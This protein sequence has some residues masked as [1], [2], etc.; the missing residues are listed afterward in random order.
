VS[1]PELRGARV[2]L[3]PPDP[4][5]DAVPLAALLSEPAVAR[6]WNGPYDA[7]R[8]RRDVLEAEPGWIIEV[9]GELAGWIQYYEETD[10][11]YR[12]VALD[13][14]LATAHHGRGLGPE[15]LRLV[16]NHFASAGHHRFTIDPAA[17]NARAIRAYEKVG[18]RPVGRLRD[19]ERAPDGTWHDGLLMDLLVSEL[20]PAS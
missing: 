13:L 17:D 7:Q 19:Y 3:R 6:W 14:S 8:A 1:L 5:A 16:V 4:A 2:R 18:F 20:R 12:H 15:A 11:D 9:D 10:P